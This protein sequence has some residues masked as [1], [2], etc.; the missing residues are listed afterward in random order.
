MI[1]PLTTAETARAALKL[2][3]QHVGQGLTC[4]AFD[5]RPGRANDNSVD[6]VLHGPIIGLT[7]RF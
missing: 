2:F 4:A 1:D 5:V 7:V 6:V 3:Q